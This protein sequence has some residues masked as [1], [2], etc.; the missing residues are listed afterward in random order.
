M[1]KVESRMELLFVHHPQ[2][3]FIL[4]TFWFMWRHVVKEKNTEAHF[5]FGVS[6][7]VGTISITFL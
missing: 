2:Q 7:I 3:C 1:E 6:F 4:P 5:A